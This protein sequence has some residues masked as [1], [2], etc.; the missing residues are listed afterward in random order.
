MVNF[1]SDF[2]EFLHSLEK[3]QKLSELTKLIE[4]Y[5]KNQF[6]M[7]IILTS[8]INSLREQLVLDLSDKLPRLAKLIPETFYGHIARIIK[9]AVEITNNVEIIAGKK[10]K[11]TL[12]AVIGHTKILEYRELTSAIVN[13]IAISEK[14]SFLLIVKTEFFKKYSA[15]LKILSEIFEKGRELLLNLFNDTENRLWIQLELALVNRVDV[16]PPI[17]E[18]LPIIHASMHIN[19]I[20][21]RLDFIEHQIKVHN[22]A[23]RIWKFPEIIKEKLRYFITNLPKLDPMVV[24]SQVLAEITTGKATLRDLYSV[25]LMLKTRVQEIESLIYH[26]LYPSTYVIEMLSEVADP[27]KSLKQIRESLVGA[28]ILWSPE[29]SLFELLGIEEIEQLDEDLILNW[30]KSEIEKMTSFDRTTLMERF[31]ESLENLIKFGIYLALSRISTAGDVKKLVARYILSMEKR[32]R[33]HPIPLLSIVLKSLNKFEEIDIG[34]AVYAQRILEIHG[35]VSYLVILDNLFK[36]KKPLCV[37]LDILLSNRKSIINRKIIATAMKNSDVLYEINA[38]LQKIGSVL[39]PRGVTAPLPWELTIKFEEKIKDWVK[40]ALKY[41]NDA[42]IPPRF[43][44]ISLYRCVEHIPKL[45]NQRELLEDQP[46]KVLLDYNRKIVESQYHLENL[47]LRIRRLCDGCFPKMISNL[48]DLLDQFKQSF[49]S[50]WELKLIENY[51][52]IIK[53][54]QFDLKMT[55]DVTALIKNILSNKNRKV[56]LLV[57]DGLRFDDFH[58]KLKKALISVG[59]NIIEEKQL[60]SLL[61]SITQISRRAIFSAEKPPPVLVLHPGKILGYSYPPEDLLLSKHFDGRTI[62]LSGPIGMIATSIKAKANSEALSEADVIAIVLS[63]LEK[64]AHGAAEGFLARITRDYASEIARIARL[65]VDTFRRISGKDVLLVIT[66]DHGLEKFTRLCEISIYELKKRFKKKD[67]LDLV[68]E[69]YISNRFAIIP[70]FNESALESARNIINKQSRNELIMIPLKDLKIQN[71]TLKMKDSDLWGLV[72]ARRAAIIFIRDKKR[73]R[74]SKLAFKNV[75]Y[76]GGLLPVETI[77][78]LG[79]FKTK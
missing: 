26:G 16:S 34:I 59:F 15:F 46:I 21:A 79:I 48:K 3:A 37:A 2:S 20:Y 72:D 54:P 68:H 65:A 14:D 61:P 17:R 29:L 75:V 70:F 12:Q 66:S 73:F 69:P 74:I 30:I 32:L 9:K 47:S 18:I 1:E 28:E 44:L 57:I 19:D 60:I 42:G 56:V 63:E 41:F 40:L 67:L 39:R 78:P 22:L 10:E 38:S 52:N 23:A 6:E 4:N 53:N 45:Y 13:F 64:A 5:F 25:I 7:K 36:G 71:V 33:N 43:E 8:I 58:T 55:S 35:P 62:Y 49:E 31:P 50:A 51:S 27:L 24:I 11:D 76:H 77:I